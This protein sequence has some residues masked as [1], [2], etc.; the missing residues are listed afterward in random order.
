[1][2]TVIQDVR[3]ATRSLW[4]RPSFAVVVVLTLALGIGANTAIFTL[5]N[6]LILRPLPVR[7]PEEL[8]IV[9]R[10]ISCCMNTGIQRN[11]DLWSYRLYHDVLD[12]SQDYF[13]GFAAVSSMPVPV[14]VRK[15]DTRDTAREVWSR[16]VSARAVS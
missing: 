2:Q 5:I 7:N 3:T 8:V 16:V 6:G 11:F 15:S 10:G 13:S 14:Q 1:M 9:G 4:R 12:R